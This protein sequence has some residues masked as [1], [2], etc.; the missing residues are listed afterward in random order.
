MSP[1]AGPATQAAPLIATAGLAAI[2]CYA[3]VKFDVL[4]GSNGTL[5][6]LLPALL[7]IAAIL[8]IGAAM[9][10][11]N[12]SPQMYAD[13]GRNRGDDLSAPALVL[14]ADQ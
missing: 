11:R 13:M 10:L 14:K 3:I 9:R 2:A 5:S 8:G 1:Q 4:I 7:P 6:W 12:R